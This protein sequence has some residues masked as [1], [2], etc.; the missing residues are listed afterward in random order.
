MKILYL[1]YLK[2][3]KAEIYMEMDAASKMEQEKGKECEKDSRVGSS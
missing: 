3:L 2:L 1:T